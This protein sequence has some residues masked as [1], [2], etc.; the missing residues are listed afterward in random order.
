[1]VWRTVFPHSLLHHLQHVFTR[2]LAGRT[3][4]QALP[5]VLI[6]QGQHF[7]CSSVIGAIRDEVPT[8][9]LM[10]MRGSLH[11]TGGDSWRLLLFFGGFTISPTSLLNR[12]T[13]FLLT[14]QPSRRNMARMRRYRTS[15]ASSSMPLA[16]QS[17]GRVG[18]GAGSA[19]TDTFS[20]AS[21]CPHRPVAPS[22]APG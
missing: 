6:D 19:G 3:D 5:R 17:A 7:K 20:D 12:S 13:C 2:E 22:N 18:L 10:A 4:S 9:N 21:P 15:G 14:V 1:M 16:A 8:P 11:P